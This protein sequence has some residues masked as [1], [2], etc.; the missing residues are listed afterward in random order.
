MERCWVYQD[1]QTSRICSLF[2]VL[3][4][5]FLCLKLSLFFLVHFVCKWLE[6]CYASI[7]C[8]NEPLLFLFWVHWHNLVIL[9]ALHAAGIMTVHPSQEPSPALF[10]LQWEWTSPWGSKVSLWQFW[11]LLDEL[12]QKLCDT[13]LKGNQKCLQC[14]SFLALSMSK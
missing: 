10:S 7:F 12:C 14:C 4:H 5:E 11:D 1:S 9:C 2:I 6:K 3:K 8:F 13:E